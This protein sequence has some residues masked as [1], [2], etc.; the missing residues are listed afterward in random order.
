MLTPDMR[1]VIQAA[2]L[3]FAAT[4]TPDGR[5]NLS[6]KGTIRVWDDT[7]LFFLDIASPGTRAN[8]THT[9]WLELNVVEQLSRRGYRFSGPAALHFEGSS[10]YGEA[11]RRVYGEAGPA[12]P[13]A[14]VVLV[15]VER[16]APLL[17]P[18]YWRVADETALRE[19]WRA[20]REALD[21]EFEAHLAR[22]GPVR[23]SPPADHRLDEAAADS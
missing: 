14:A 22:V 1:A 8:L 2:H 9:P 13:V 11:T 5:P 19:S 21:R 20:R 23:V 18:A 10:V 4:V 6:P 17:S 15:T 7:H 3:C 12:H 16:A